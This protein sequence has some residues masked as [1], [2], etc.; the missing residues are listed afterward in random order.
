MIKRIN[1]SKILMNQVIV[2]LR[3]AYHSLFSLLCVLIPSNIC[4]NHFLLLL[5]L[6]LNSIILDLRIQLDLLR[7]A[8]CIVHWTSTNSNPADI[9]ESLL[10]RIPWR[11]QRTALGSTSKNVQASLATIE[12]RIRALCVSLAAHDE[13]IFQHAR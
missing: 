1:P 5:F 12:H 8:D 10:E 13:A 3:I 11:W 7:C 6:P 4:S 2:V 9:P